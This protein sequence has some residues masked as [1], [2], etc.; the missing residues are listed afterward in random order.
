M[1]PADNGRTRGTSI[2]FPLTYL[3]FCAVCGR[4]VP[5]PPAGS[6]RQTAMTLEAGDRRRVVDAAVLRPEFFNNLSHDDSGRF[7]SIGKVSILLD[8]WRSVEMPDGRAPAL[9]SETLWSSLGCPDACHAL[10]LNGIFLVVQKMPAE[11]DYPEGTEAWVHPWVEEGAARRKHAQEVEARA[12]TLCG[13]PSVRR[14]LVA[15]A[16]LA[17]PILHASTSPDQPGWGVSAGFFRGGP[18][19]FHTLPDS[20][21][22]QGWPSAVACE[23]RTEHKTGDYIL[24]SEAKKAVGA[25]SGYRVTSHVRLVDWQ[26]GTEINRKTFEATPPRRVE[27]TG[28][29]D[30]KGHTASA[31]ERWITSH[32]HRNGSRGRAGELQP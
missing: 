14:V 31:V 15:T 30:L 12:K 18:A 26:T 11:F 22:G 17:E 16:P 10:R 24:F 3:V 1:V 7:A 29:F 6:F 23:T 19:T 32:L 5:A 27:N 4:G 21:F 8:P 9:L 13:A 20:R 25:V 28:R 2:L